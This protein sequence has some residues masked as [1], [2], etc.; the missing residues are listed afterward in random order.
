MHKTNTGSNKKIRQRNSRIIYSNLE[1][2]LMGRGDFFVTTE[3]GK[4]G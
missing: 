3:K 4:R 2:D 1:E